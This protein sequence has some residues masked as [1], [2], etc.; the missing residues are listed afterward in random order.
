MSCIY[1]AINDK[2]DNRFLYTVKIND[3]SIVE[4]ACNS[5]VHTE[6]KHKTE[7]L[8]NSLDHSRYDH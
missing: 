7:H 5:E 8:S 4:K 6:I 3:F 1:K 2:I